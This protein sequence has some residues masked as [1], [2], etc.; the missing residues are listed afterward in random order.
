M[1]EHITFP[2]IRLFVLAAGSFYYTDGAAGLEDIRLVRKS[3]G[4]PGWLLAC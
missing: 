3:W 4:F 2:Y 1:R